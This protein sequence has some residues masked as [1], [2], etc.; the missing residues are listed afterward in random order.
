[1]IAADPGRG[2]PTAS[3]LLFLNGQCEYP[4]QERFF[5]LMALHSYF[6]NADCLRDLFLNRI[7]RAQPP[8]TLILS[9]RWTT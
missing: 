1:M 2:N 4:Q 3:D 5:E 8:P 7:K 9:P 6:L